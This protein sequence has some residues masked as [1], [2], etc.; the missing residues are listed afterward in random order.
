MPGS[1]ACAAVAPLSGGTPVPAPPLGWVLTQ[2]VPPQNQESLTFIRVHCHFGTLGHGRPWV[3]SGRM[4]RISSRWLG[5]GL[6]GEGGKLHL[7]Q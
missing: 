3:E 4:R 7:D 6:G 5:W 2:T 1:S